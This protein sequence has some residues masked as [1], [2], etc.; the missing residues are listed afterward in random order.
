MTYDMPA[1]LVGDLALRGLVQCSLRAAA[2]ASCPSSS[3]VGTVQSI[4]GSG[5]EPPLL[6]GNVF[7]T[8]PK[9]PGDPAGLSV[10]VPARLGPVDA[11]IVIVGVRLQL[12]PDGGLHV[13]SDPIPPLQE[14]IPLA[15][16]QLTVRIDRDGFMRNP[17]SCGEKTANG[18]FDSIGS[19]HASISSKLSF[20]GC[21][22]LA[23][24]PSIRAFIGARHRTRTGAHPPFTTVITSRGDDATIRSAH[25]RLPKGVASNTRSLNAACASELF[26]AGRCPE[27]SHIAN[28][29]ALSPLLRDP[30]TGPVYLVKRPAGQTGL[31][32]LVVQFRS[33]VALTLEG[34]VN[35]GRGGGIGT[36]FPVVPDLPITRFTLRFHGGAYGALALT[37]N[38]CR[39]RRGRRALR[40]PSSFQGQNGRATKLSPRMAVR[41]CRG[42]RGRARH[43]RTAKRRRR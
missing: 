19:E 21:D 23:F 31:P 43:R 40:L 26:A 39:A 34:I 9:Q 41:G 12:R 35:I 24:A 2:A 3:R 10:Q 13:V 8:R 16:R 36:T 17:T 42:M 32:R 27:V 22:R 25:V 7:L 11:G 4:D 1:G 30:V 20:T 37:R 6:P 38:I 15:I 14:G 5:T 18:L 29:V 28:A 33:P